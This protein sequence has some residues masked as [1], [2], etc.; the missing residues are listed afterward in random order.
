MADD[1]RAKIAQA[2]QN[3]RGSEAAFS[4][5]C[6]GIG[7]DMADAIRDWTEAEKMIRAAQARRE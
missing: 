5:L 2:R 3:W 6:K 7:W 1:T 4:Q